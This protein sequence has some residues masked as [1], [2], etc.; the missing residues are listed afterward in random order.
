MPDIQLSINMQYLYLSA[1]RQHNSK[2]MPMAHAIESVMHFRVLHPQE[3]L[4]CVLQM[5]CSRKACKMQS[6]QSLSLI[7][8]YTLWQKTLFELP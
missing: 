7:G 4:G 8:G 1:Y 6:A 2:N 5:E 3:N